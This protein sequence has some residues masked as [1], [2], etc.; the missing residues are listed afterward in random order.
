MPADATPIVSTTVLGPAAG[1]AVSQYQ[2][3]QA[4]DGRAAVYQGTAASSGATVA[5]YTDGRY[6]MPKDTTWTALAGLPA[7]WDQSASKVLYKDVGDQDFCIGVFADDALTSADTCEVALNVLLRPKIDLLNDPA[8]SPNLTGTL[9]LGTPAAPGFLPPQKFGGTT[10]FV[11][12]A[13]S[14]V[15]VVDLISR[16]GFK[17]LGSKAIVR[18]VFN[19]INDGAAGTQDISLGV[20]SGSHATDMDSVTQRLLAH[21]DGGATAINF[22]SADGTTSTSRVSSG[23]TYTESGTLANRVEIWLDFRDDANVQIYVNGANVLP[24]STF[25]VAAAASEW[26][27]IIHLEKGSGTDIYTLE[28]HH[29]EVYT[30]E[31]RDALAY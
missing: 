9:A 23:V 4:A 11:L 3:V 16:C 21:I 20:A 5:L 19:V 12:S 17:A 15:Q 2:I 14:E 18:I 25:N 22:E 28:V 24:S 26:F 6:T 1:A 29:F 30:A 10:R 31:W 8:T 13:T 7:Y 27:P